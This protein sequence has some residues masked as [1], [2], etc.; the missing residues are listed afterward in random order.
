[1]TESASR[2]RRSANLLLVED[3][4]GD[5]RLVEE[6]FR[7]RSDDCILHVV[8]DGDEALDFLYQRGDHATAPR[9]DLVLLDWNIPR[10]S[11]EH[12]LAKLKADPERKHIPVTVLTGS[13]DDTDVA[14]SYQNYANACLQKAVE[15]GEFMDT[16]EV[17]TDF[18]LSTARLPATE[19]DE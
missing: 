18:W 1:M 15:P 5:A 11:G 3:N 12:L 2:S 17:F 7:G 8:S 10:T 6:A 13:Q 16:I 9:P 14:R 4:P 19:K